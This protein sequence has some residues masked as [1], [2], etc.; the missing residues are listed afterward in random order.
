MLLAGSMVLNNVD[1]RL[2]N[3]NEPKM[4]TVYRVVLD[5]YTYVCQGFS[6]DPTLLCKHCCIIRI[7][8]ECN[9]NFTVKALIVIKVVLS[10]WYI[11]W[12]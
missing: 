9:E 5:L 7:L 1:K 11:R 10:W 4:F 6:V 8:G 12:Q 3:V 2:N